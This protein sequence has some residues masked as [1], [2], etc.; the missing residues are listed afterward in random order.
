[1]ITTPIAV[2]KANTGWKTFL[3]ILISVAC[4]VYI[5]FK[6][7]YRQLTE[8]IS[9]TQQFWVF[10]ALL[11]FLFSKLLSSFR[12][13]IYFKNINIHLSE[14]TNIKLYLLG[15]F[16]NLFLPGSVSGDGYKVVRLTRLYRVPFKKT[17]TAVLL[18][19]LSGLIALVLLLGFCWLITFHGERWGL[20]VMSGTIAMVGI[21]Y[22]AVKWF[23]PSFLRSFFSTFAFGMAVQLLQIISMFC[24]LRSLNIQSN[25]V[26]YILLFLVSSVVAV[27]PFTIGGLGARE[28][29]FLWGSKIFLLDSTI[30]V[31]ASALFYLTTVVSSLI[32]MYFIFFDPLK[33]ADADRIV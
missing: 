28:M 20:V 26:E 13:N 7:D 30:A 4:L 11:S 14:W 31:S 16:Y 21:F 10:L 6:I 8:A 5:S 24:L 12:L 27:L 25:E 1:M 3:K 23:F 33:S 19:R 22:L 9:S 15:M 18:D 17:A 2:K 32:G 29:V